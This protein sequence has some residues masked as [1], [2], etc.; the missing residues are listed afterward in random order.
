LPKEGGELILFKLTDNFD[1][2]KGYLE[3]DIRYE[4][5]DEA[6]ELLGIGEEVQLSVGRK[7]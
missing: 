1:G 5:D 4:L 6:E 3:V 7:D 2:G